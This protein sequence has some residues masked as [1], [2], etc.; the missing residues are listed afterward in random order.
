M[1]IGL[2]N[3]FGSDDAFGPR[4][5]ERLR[6][7][8]PENLD[9]SDIVD[10][11]TD[12]LGHFDRFAGCDRIILVDAL[13][14]PHG[15]FGMSGQV[16]MFDHD[17]LIS[18]PQNSRDAHHISPSLAVQLF[19]RLHPQARTRFTVVGLCVDRIAAGSSVWL[20]EDVLEAAIA[21]I[22]TICET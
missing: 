14:D 13:E 11:G 2:G 18:L 19:A 21:F 5:I 7:N 8:C 20:T 17:T 1:V 3:L 22:H 16:V 15:K 10:A 12:L 4:V 6:Q 9:L